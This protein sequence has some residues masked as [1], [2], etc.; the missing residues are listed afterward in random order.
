MKKLTTLFLAVAVLFILN[1]CEAERLNPLDPLNTTSPVYEISGSVRTAVFPQNPV[2]GVIVS[3]GNGSATTMTDS[4]GNYLIRLNTPFEGILRFSRNGFKADSSFISWNNSRKIILNKALAFS[5]SLTGFSSR[6]EVLNRF[7]SVKF[8]NI[9]FTAEVADSGA[10]VDSV[11]AYDKES[12]RKYY[13]PFERNSSVYTALFSLIDFPSISSFRDLTGREFSVVIKEKTGHEI[14]S[15]LGSVKRIIEEEPV[16]TFPVNGQNLS[17]AQQLS[18]QWQAYTPGF[19]HS[20]FL[21][22]YT[23]EIT[24]Q[25]ILKSPSVSSGIFS[26]APEITLPPGDYFWVLYAQDNFGNLA[27]S[28]PAS[29]RVN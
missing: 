9:R 8:I 26:Y 20:F 25:L 17:S 16:L 23:D 15:G 22:I 6:S 5:P 4:E 2:T 28:K 14:T 1:G 3:L 7:P 29:F 27:R 12:G 11:F 19:G 13:L 24:P 18:F 21:E 10:T